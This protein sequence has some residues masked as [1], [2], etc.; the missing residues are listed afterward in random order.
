MAYRSQRSIVLTTSLVYYKGMKVRQ[1]Q[2]EEAHRGTV[3]S[4]HAPRPVYNF[5]CSPHAHQP[6]SSPEPILQFLWKLHY[7][8]MIDYIIG[9][10]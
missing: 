9:H 1:S 7:I 5:S 3:R 2:M 8:V 6:G 4:F 10:W